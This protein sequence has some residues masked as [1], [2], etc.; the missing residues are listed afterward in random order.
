MHG[1]QAC[2]AQPIRLYPGNSDQSAGPV[3]R[4]TLHRGPTRLRMGSEG[5]SR[6]GVLLLAIIMGR[7]YRPGPRP[8]PERAPAAPLSCRRCRAPAPVTGPLRAFGRPAAWA[9][10][11]PAGP[12]AAPGLARP[13]PPHCPGSHPHRARGAAR[14]RFPC[15]RLPRTAPDLP[16]VRRHARPQACHA[17]ALRAVGPARHMGTCALGCRL[18]RPRPA[19][20]DAEAC[21]RFPAQRNFGQAGGWQCR[22]C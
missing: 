13:D 3:I 12:V 22:S 5:R 19:A 14:R 15:P 17:A 8:R 4:R 16:R 20:Y 9:S 10:P 1:W 6:L 7:A 21:P 18:A 2:G 11:G